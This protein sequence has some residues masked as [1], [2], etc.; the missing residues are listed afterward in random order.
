M[1]KLG[2][3]FWIVS[4]IVVVLCINEPIFI[5]LYL[6]CL[7]L[8]FIIYVIKSKKGKKDTSSSIFSS[9]SFTSP[10]AET[11]TKDMDRDYFNQMSKVVDDLMAEYDFACLSAKFGKEI[12][13]CEYQFTI[14]GKILENRK[15]KIRWLF[16]LDV[17][18]CYKG[19]GLPCDIINK[20]SYGLYYFIERTIVENRFSY[21]NHRKLYRFT[22]HALSSTIIR[23]ITNPSND[24]PEVEGRFLVANIYGRFDNSLRQRYIVRLYRFA[25]IVAKADNVVT[26]EEAAWLSSIM[27]LQ[28]SGENT[29]V[30][31]EDG[32][33]H[34][35]VY[36]ENIYGE[37][38][39]TYQ[40]STHQR[41]DEQTE[42][43]NLIGLES[44]KKEVENLSDYIHIQNTRQQKGMKIPPISYH[45]VFTGN[46]GTGKTT[47]ARILAKIYKN[48]GVVSRGHLVETDRSGLIAE[49]VG[50]TAIKTNKVID[51]AMGG[52]LFIDEAYSLLGG[53]EED[54]GKEAVATLLKRMEDER[55]RFVVILAGYTNEMKDFINSNPGLQSRFSRYIE[56]PDYNADELYQI[57]CKQLK[58][59]DYMITPKAAEAAKE[60]FIYHVANKDANFGNARFVRNVFE[61]TLQRQATRLSKEVNLTTAKLAEI[62]V[63]DL[64]T[65]A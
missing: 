57:F 12:N 18:R 3:G 36:D 64:P 46:P 63:E 15:E 45:C 62:T 33:P 4:L 22:N 27:Q 7:L 43:Q 48:L 37:W 61:H 29:T 59:F 9:S 38:S 24:V 39:T 55:G 6:V 53:G 1:N 42:L 28:S 19:L 51:K 31:G 17:V 32:N 44:V 10:G 52:V 16:W 5:V 49:Y 35:N 2:C 11:N 65:E 41:T 58:Q 34:T 54:Y 20:T 56:F 23:G 13:N 26:D 47:V 25:S 60:L 8:V 30:T 21:E 50:Q 14:E 40:S